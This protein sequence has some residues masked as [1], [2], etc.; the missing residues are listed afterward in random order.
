MLEAAF[1]T[2]AIVAFL[3]VCGLPLG[4]LVV[5][6]EG[7]QRSG[8]IGGTVWSHNRSGVYI[9]NRSI[10]VNPNTDRQSAVRN[11]VRAISIAWETIL[12]QVQRDA[13]DVYAANVTWQNRLGQSINLT[14]LNHF[15]RCNTPRVMNAI[16]RVDA[17]PVIFD[18]AAA[19]T[20]L[21]ASAEELT[22]LITVNG[23]LL[24]P[25]IG[26]A[27][28]WYFISMGIPQNASRRYFGGPWRQ[29]AAI[30][31]AGPPPFPALLATAFPFA[32]GNRIWVRSRV[33]RGDGR[34]SE[35]AQVNFL[36]DPGAPVA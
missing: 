4:A 8:S 24:H 23:D 17:A 21:T 11:A 16:A 18:L 29:L 10:P 31:G 26:E 15:I 12:T 33:A 28:A 14:G 25:W 6:P 30:P 3:C 32:E 1:L 5:L 9:R 20:E 27:N 35:F 7:Q 22:Q 13:W 36:A 34:L 2:S 19:D